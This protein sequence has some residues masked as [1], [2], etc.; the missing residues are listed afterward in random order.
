MGWVSVV[1][2]VYFFFLLS[3]GSFNVQR[4]CISAPQSSLKRFQTGR[5]KAI[6]KRKY[7]H[8]PLNYPQ[9]H[10]SLSLMVNGFELGTSCN[11]PEICSG[12]KRIMF[13]YA[14]VAG[15]NVE[16]ALPA[17]YFFCRALVASRQPSFPP[18]WKQA[19][20]GSALP[21]GCPAGAPGRDPLSPV[22][23]IVAW[24]GQTSKW[25]NY[26]RTSQMHVQS[27]A[28]Q[29]AVHQLCFS[30]SFVEQKKNQLS[31][32]LRHYKDKCAKSATAYT[33][34]HQ[35]ATKINL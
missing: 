8:S 34:W 35:E 12:H 19:G 22:G 3:L 20:S 28:L 17:L 33:N 30:F 24:T 16:N 27:P 25:Q 23:Q 6:N 14:L 9:I 2:F 15:S 31:P 11:N 21:S 32:S 10:L 29:W 7:R 5:Q 13:I 4:Q 26:P 1:F 18:T